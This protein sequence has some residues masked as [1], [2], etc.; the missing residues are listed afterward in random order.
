MGV[1]LLLPGSIKAVVSSVI[2]FS[3]WFS[4]FNVSKR[5]KATYADWNK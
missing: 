3:I 1:E 4:Y 2:G 5:V